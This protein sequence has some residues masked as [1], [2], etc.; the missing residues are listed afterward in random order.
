M[1]L[2]PWL[3]G[4]ELD[5]D[6]LLALGSE[7]SQTGESSDSAKLNMA[8]LALNMSGRFNGVSRI[9]QKVTQTI[10]QPFF[11]RWP[12]ADIPAD[13][14]TN[15]VHTPSWDSPESDAI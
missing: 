12:A 14:V 8:L 6:Q 2:G 9:H 4:R 3:T 15:G 13:Y 5:V 10:F 7:N 1:Y 11:P